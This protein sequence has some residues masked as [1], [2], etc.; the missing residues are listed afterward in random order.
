VLAAAIVAALLA[1]APA[2]SASGPR[3]HV[4]SLTY[5][6]GAE[7]NPY[8]VYVPHSYYERS[9]RA[10]LLVMTHGCQTSAKQQMRANL[11]NRLAERKGFIVVY[12]DVTEAEVAQPGPLARCWQFFNSESWHRGSGDAA[13]I[14]GITRAAIKRWRI[15][16]ERVYMMGMSAGSFMTSVMSAAYP[17]LY[18]AV[19]IMAGGAYADPSCLFVG[20][21]IPAETSAQMAFDEMG[22]RARIVPRLVMGGDADQGVPPACADK[23]LEQGVRT[24]NLVIGQS[25]TAPISLT[26]VSQHEVPNPGGYDS[27]VK[28]YRDP[29]GCLIGQ[30]WLIHGMNH[31]WSGGSSDPK[32]ASFTDPKGPNGAEASWRFLSRFE[33]RSTS[34]PCAEAR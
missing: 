23:A 6:S 20:P 18:A 10:P 14:A 29:S 7:A 4:H 19:G 5:G 31:F 21:G 30:R 16:R 8:L 11:Y 3:G 17:D 9:R 28:T 22:S 2:A 12:P 33:K 25:Q 34:M 1:L 24:N 26:P 32:W 15:D 27:T 13:A